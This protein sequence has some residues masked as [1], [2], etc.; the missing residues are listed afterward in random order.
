MDQRFFF[1]GIEEKNAQHTFAD[2]EDMIRRLTGS[3]SKKKQPSPPTPA[4]SPD[5]FD[6]VPA[7]KSPA[8]GRFG[9][10]AF[11]NRTPKPQKDFSSP[12]PVSPVRRMD[13]SPASAATP[14][15]AVANVVPG[16]NS[17][18]FVTPSLASAVSMQSF[19]QL[20]S[21]H[22]IGTSFNYEPGYNSS[23]VRVET[24]LPDTQRRAQGGQARFNWSTNR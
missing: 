22:E 4:Q 2:T 14:S 8:G 18:A 20:S 9:M 5:V 21:L 10:P 11:R 16:K 15:P 3:A 17:T 6:A 19:G 23:R 12:A 7:P 24:P 1:C 13:L